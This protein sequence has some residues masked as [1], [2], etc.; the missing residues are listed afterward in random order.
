[1]AAAGAVEAAGAAAAAAATIA[2]A[3]TPAEAAAGATTAA[4]RA[5][6]A[7]G[8]LTV[9]VPCILDALLVNIKHG[10]K[11]VDSQF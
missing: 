11:L 9:L 5:V 3:T 4:T 7:R 8:R 10:E 2:A 6:V 1:M